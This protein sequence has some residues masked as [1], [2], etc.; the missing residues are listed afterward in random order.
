MLKRRIA[1]VM[2]YTHTGMSKNMQD[3]KGNDIHKFQQELQEKVSAYISEKSF[4]NHFKGYHEKLPRIDLLNILS[5]YAGYADWSDFK[6]ANHDKVIQITGITG[7]N[8]T[9]YLLAVMA[10]MAFVVFWIIIR[11]SSS[12]SYKFCFVDKVSREPINGHPVEVEILLEHESPLLLA[13]DTFG[14]FSYKTSDSRVRFL[15]RSAYY[16]PD[17][18]T[19]LLNK[20][21]RNEIIPLRTDDYALM[22]N[23]FSNSKAEDWRKRRAQLEEIIA[24]NAM[25]YQVHGSPSQGM[26]LYNKEE[27]IDMMTIPTGH[28]KNIDILD[29][30]YRDDKISFLKF[31]LNIPQ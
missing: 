15:V 27:F 8:K 10:L 24:D 3:W 7:S 5:Q 6:Q 13:C 30:F 12:T 29:I 11:A 16:Y 9:F 20:A 2:Q 18:I 28:L 19:R 25:I 4:Y 31:N 26:E 14:C 1:D 22:I 21:S 17:T 23:Y